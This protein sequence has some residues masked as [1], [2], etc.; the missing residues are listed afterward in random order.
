MDGRQSRSGRCGMNKTKTEKFLAVWF[1]SSCFV[2][3]LCLVGAGIEISTQDTGYDKV[4]CTVVGGSR[5]QS[6]DIVV[7]YFYKN[8]TTYTEVSIGA[9]DPKAPYY[10]GQVYSCWLK[11]DG[12]A[13]GF[14]NGFA[15]DSTLRFRDK[16]DSKDKKGNKVGFYMMWT[17][18]IALTVMGVMFVVFMFCG[19]CI[20][21]LA[22]HPC[23]DGCFPYITSSTKADGDRLLHP[24]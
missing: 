7:V 11:N 14:A 8:E 23:F 3:V 21:V 1:F 10:V 20:S 17:G 6:N 19:P 15:N 22:E 5:P 4:P 12:S 24:V 2:T 16:P 13:N 9:D 18:L